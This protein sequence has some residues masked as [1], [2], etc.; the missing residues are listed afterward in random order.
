MSGRHSRRDST[1]FYADL[2]T[3][4]FA[5][6]GR[7]PA[8]GLDCFGVGY[9]LTRRQRGWVPDEAFPGTDRYALECWTSTRSAVVASW[10]E[11]VGDTPRS[12]KNVGDAI[13]SVH[14]ADMMPHVSWLVQ[15]H[16]P[17]VVLSARRAHG[18]YA[19]RMDKAVSW[20]ECLGVYRLRE[21]PKL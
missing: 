18:V 12:A 16:H 6:S 4:K 17:R 21:R 10:W 1:L 3:V 11:R 15:P 5:D 7:D 9:E 14:G 13:L 8:T 19:L 2:L 20:G